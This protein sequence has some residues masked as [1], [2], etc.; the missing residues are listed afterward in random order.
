MNETPAICNDPGRILG[1]QPADLTRAINRLQAMPVDW[2]LMD[3]AEPVAP[4]Q[5][6]TIARAVSAEGPGTFLGK[7][8]R[9]ITFKPS[10]TPGW[11]FNRADL[12]EHLPVGVSVHNVWTTGGVISN[13]VLRSGPPNNY[14]RMVEHII[15]LRMGMP[16]DNLI[17]EMDSGDPPLFD[18]GSMDLVE[19]LESAGCR[20]TDAP[21][22]WVT[23][24][25]PVTLG[26]PN[27]SF[28]TLFPADPQR[29]L[30]TID[31]AVDFPTAIGQQRIRFPLNPEL[32]RHG[33]AARTNTSASKKLY[34]Q[35]IG[36]LFADVRNLGYS[37][38]NVLI[39]GRRRY[40]NEPKLLH[41]GKSLEAVWHR[42]ILDLL[43][44][45]ALIERGRFVGHV[46]SYK[47]G[48]TLDVNMV[49]ALY[50]HDL[51]TTL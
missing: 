18:R 25:E 41:N 32:F 4:R 39:A 23:V 36:R 48:H 5:Q 8:R 11:W 46:H 42:A 33:A 29:P 27:G 1:G 43:A 50:Q 7:A 49:R 28:L 3:Q 38:K 15:A 47:A 35:T 20:E 34:C 2:D 6:A 40:V 26:G 9:H 51:L 17:I 14:I 31:C 44:A 45:L 22:E 24:T 13:I 30:L 37:E 12:A 16:I 21:V 10:D 19:A